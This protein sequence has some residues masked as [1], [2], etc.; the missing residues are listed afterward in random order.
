MAY[1]S[2]EARNA[3]QRRRRA[4]DPI[5]AQ[6][7]QRRWRAANPDKARAASRRANHQKSLTGKLQEETWKRRGIAV[8]E[9]K[10]ALLSC[11][12]LCD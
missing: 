2:R 11:N 5:K 4:A 10:A 8:S 9:A 1:R 12:G 7:A 6:E 3:A